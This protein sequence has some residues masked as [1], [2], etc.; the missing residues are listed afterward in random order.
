MTET[1]RDPE[2]QAI[3]DRIAKLKAVLT[4]GGLDVEVKAEITLNFSVVVKD[5]EK[6]KAK[7]DRPRG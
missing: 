5:P 7:H 6:G 4:A 1:I 3:I 2:L